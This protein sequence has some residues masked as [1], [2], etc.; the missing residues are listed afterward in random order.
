M[1]KGLKTKPLYRFYD[2]SSG[3][4]KRPGMVRSNTEGAAIDVEVWRVPR[5]KVGDFLDNVKAPL[6][7]GTVELEDGTN[8]KGFLCESYVSESF[9]EITSYGGW[10]DYVKSLK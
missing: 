6:T 1:V 2:I 10:R 8:V 3:N 4:L 7:L 5:S 9:P